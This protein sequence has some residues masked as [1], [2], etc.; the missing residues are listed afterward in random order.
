MLNDEQKKAIDTQ[1]NAV[2]N[3]WFRFFLSYDPY[4]TL[5]QVKCPV[6]ALNGAKDVQ[7]PAL[8]NLAAIQKALAEGENKNFKTIRLENLNHLFQH[9]KTGAV[10]EYGQIE[11]TISPEVLEIIDGWIQEVVQKN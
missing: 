6:L 1:V 9:C 2:N 7:V 11:E 8:Q 5:T 3:R 4:P 10:A